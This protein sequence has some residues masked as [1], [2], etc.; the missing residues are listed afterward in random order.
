VSLFLRRLCGTPAGGEM[1]RVPL[2]KGELSAESRERSALDFHPTQFTMEFIDS[3]KA[4][5]P[6]LAEL[7][8]TLGNLHEYK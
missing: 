4:L 3:Q 6:D 7:Y 5:Y 2:E 8:T 1:V